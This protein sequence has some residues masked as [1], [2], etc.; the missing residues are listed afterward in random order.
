MTSGADR[1]AATDRMMAMADQD[2]DGKQ[3]DA[4]RDAAS[5]ARWYGPDAGHPSVVRRRAQQARAEQD[6]RVARSIAADQAGDVDP[7]TGLWRRA[8]WS[9]DLSGPVGIERL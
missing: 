6:A 5:Y 7:A 3:P 1:S 8:T 9:E 2:D 4:A